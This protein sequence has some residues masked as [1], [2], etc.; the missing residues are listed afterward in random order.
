MGQIIIRGL[1][2][3]FIVLPSKYDLYNFIRKLPFSIIVVKCHFFVIE[4]KVSGMSSSTRVPT[5]FSIIIIES[6]VQG[7]SEVIYLKGGVFYI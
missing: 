1:S 7:H 6:P 5:K 4:L 3:E 2:S